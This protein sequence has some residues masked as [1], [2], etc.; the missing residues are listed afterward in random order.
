MIS[1]NMNR[2]FQIIFIVI[3]AIFFYACKKKKEILNVQDLSVATESRLNNIKYAWGQWWICGG[4]FFDKSVIYSSQDGVHFHEIELPKNFNQKELFGMD[5]KDSVIVCAGVDATIL[6]SKDEGKNWNA[7]VNG[8]W[9]NIYNIACRNSNNL[10]ALGYNNFSNGFYHLLDGE[11]NNTLSEIVY[12]N[13]ALN[14]VYFLNEDIGYMSGYGIILKTTDGGNQ[15]N[16]LDISNDNFKGMCWKN[17][18]EGV[19]VGYEGSIYSTQNGGNT[20]YKSQAINNPLKKQKHYLDVAHNSENV[21]IAVG[22]KGLVSIS[23]DMGLHW[24]NVNTF[25]NKDLRSVIFT[26]T[27]ICYMCGEQGAIFR[28]LL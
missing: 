19:V 9:V 12:Q 14:R 3:I 7:K 1:A 28:I 27:N 11:G 13:Y 20:W 8:T 5:I 2:R 26:E 22:E 4:I 17:E 18:S 15:W 10:Y 16:A 24:H 6:Q 23:Y 25:T 21:C